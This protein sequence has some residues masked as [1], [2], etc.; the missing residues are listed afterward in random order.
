MVCRHHRA[1]ATEVAPCHRVPALS[2]SPSRSAFAAC[3]CCCSS[4]LHLSSFAKTEHCCCHGAA[5]LF[6]PDACTVV[7]LISSSCLCRN[8]GGFAVA[9]IHSRC[10]SGP[11]GATPPSP[12]TVVTDHLALPLLSGR[13]S[14][15]SVSLFSS[16]FGRGTPPLLIVYRSLSQIAL[17]LETREN[18]ETD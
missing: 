13:C 17:K 4:L 7:P 9:G 14:A 2:P 10:Y 11:L 3:C 15:I 12:S 5:L 16:L 18:F 6:G 1:A 8:H